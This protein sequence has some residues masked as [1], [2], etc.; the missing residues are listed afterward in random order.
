MLLS[1]A[2]CASTAVSYR[3]DEDN[4]V[5]VGY[6]MTITPDGEDISKYA[7]K[8]ANY[9]ESLGF[10][11][12]TSEVDG[13]TTLSGTKTVEC[14]TMQEAVDTLA[15]AL[16]GEDSLA[17]RREVHLR[18]ILFSGRFQSGGERIAEGFAPPQ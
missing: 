10:T 5:A 15:E 14:E 3:I 6:S 12:Q 7:D 18:A 2:A 17:L 9:W 11:V 4:R 8:I 16:T 1:L 13:T